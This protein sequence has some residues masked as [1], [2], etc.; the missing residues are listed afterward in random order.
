MHK[1]CKLEVSMKS[2]QKHPSFNILDHCLVKPWLHIL[3]YPKVKT[4]QL[5]CHKIIAE[6]DGF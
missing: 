3:D 1:L 2:L 4:H 6:H 5:T